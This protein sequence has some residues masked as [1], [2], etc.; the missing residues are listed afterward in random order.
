MLRSLTV[1]DIVL[2]D[3]LDL[4]F[5]PGLSVLTGETGA[6]KSILLDAL[7]LVLGRRA[8]LALIR[9]G[10]AQGS[11][12]AEFAVSE[13]SDVAELLERNGISLIDNALVLRRV[14]TDDGRSRAFANDQAISVGLLNTIGDLLVE[15]HGQHGQQGLMNASTHRVL[16]DLYG[17]LTDASAEVAAK[18]GSM[19]DMVFQVE[20]I[21]ARIHKAR[22]DEEY[23][24]HAVQELALLAPKPGEEEELAKARSTMMHGEQ[25]SDEVASALDTLMDDKGAENSLR[26]ALR[27]LERIADKAGDELNITMDLMSKAFNG[28]GDAI[29]SLETAARNLEFDQ[30]RLDATEERLFALRAAA[31]KH[32]CQVETLPEVHMALVKQLDALDSG[33][34]ELAQA[35]ARL[36]DVTSDYRKLAEKLSTDRAS[37]ARRLDVDINNELPPLKLER[38]V[39]QT[40]VDVLPTEQW[41][42][43]G[44]DRVAFNVSTNTGSQMGPLSKIASG[45]E[46]SRFSLAIKV[47]LAQAGTMKTMV[48][49]EI[50]QGIG[51]AVAAAI[52]ER[53]VRLSLD[54]QIMVVTHSPQV[55]ARG[56]HHMRV[57]KATEG[58]TTLTRVDPLTLD[59]RREEIARMLAG[60]D[61][62]DEAR[63][64]AEQLMKGETVP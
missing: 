3:Y 14:L 54:A 38:A 5:Q 27:R 28:L 24:R 45:G 42:V 57:G 51:G 35:Q 49:D 10:C 56:A 53:L 21:T 17:G 18:Y 1:R 39:F 12:T 34:E 11:A 8:D 19:V 7:G 55:A 20:E 2:I 44:A 37:A 47:V 9:T 59:D 13:H 6:G 41:G 23:L 62:T 4:E 50:D 61:V 30:N 63:A 25:V 15:I 52:G 22:E 36:A 31:R 26:N 43:N 33:E 60:A 32:S 46:L 40:K 64:A 29:S 58:G 16:L 48:F